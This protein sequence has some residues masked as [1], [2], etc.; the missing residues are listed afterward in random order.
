M[1]IWPCPHCSARLK[2][3]EDAIGRRARCMRCK[4]SVEVPCTSSVS[5][6]TVTKEQTPLQHP[7][8]PPHLPA[9]KISGP[10]VWIS[11]R[12][13][14]ILAATVTTVAS[15]FLF[16]RPN[17]NNRPEPVSGVVQV[18]APMADP[19]ATLQWLDK[20]RDI[21]LEYH[22]KLKYGGGKK[23]F[24]YDPRQVEAKWN[25]VNKTVTEDVRRQVDRSALKYF[26]V[27]AAFEELVQDTEKELEERLIWLGIRYALEDKVGEDAERAY[28]L[29]PDEWI[30]KQDVQSVFDA[31]RKAGLD[32]AKAS[33]VVAMAYREMRETLRQHYPRQADAMI[34][35]VDAVYQP[36]VVGRYERDWLDKN[37]PDLL[38][39]L[40]IAGLREAAASQEIL[41][42]FNADQYRSDLAQYGG[43]RTAIFQQHAEWVATYKAEELGF[44]A[45]PNYRAMARSYPPALRETMRAKA[46]KLDPAADPGLYA[47]TL[48]L[49]TFDLIP[50][51]KQQRARVVVYP[52]NSAILVKLNQALGPKVGFLGEVLPGEPT[53]AF[54]ISGDGSRLLCAGKHLIEALDLKTGKF[55]KPIVLPDSDPP[56]NAVAASFLGDTVYV[57]DQRRMLRKFEIESGREAKKFTPITLTHDETELTASADGRWLAACGSNNVQVYQ[58][59]TGS[60]VAKFFAKGLVQDL[61]FASDSKTLLVGGQGRV[62]WL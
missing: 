57:A 45:A 9:L 48:Q 49:S 47:H 43:Q 44:L 22:C 39:R 29:I 34:A 10:S 24:E 58:A 61:A 28:E 7:S 8:I 60:E 1:I 32:I 13:A 52:Q 36:L 59:D 15:A 30:V 55:G 46:E 42:L 19:T 5:D 2:A 50:P 38:R 35:T 16:M 21:R 53:I 25:A 17:S 14:A 37:H 12:N 20:V 33:D 6:A 11:L 40:Q 23:L 4:N 56:L 54:A 51:S 62:W 27:R 31:M 41:D 26:A 3:T 18:R